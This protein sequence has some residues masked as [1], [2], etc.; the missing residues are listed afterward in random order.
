MT[1]KDDKYA[2]LRQRVIAG[3]IGVIIL[4]TA[5]ASGHWGF[6]AA[7]LLLNYLSL[8]EFY[9]LVRQDGHLP[10]S[11]FGSFAGC[12]L[13]VLTFL[14][15]EQILPRTYFFIM[16]PV[17]AL[18]FFIKLYQSEQKPFIS[19]AFTF[20]GIFY[21]AVPLSLLVVCAYHPGQYS[22][23]I[24]IG[25]L[26]LL[27]GSDTGAYFAGKS[28]GKTPLFP[29]IS[30]KKT[31]EGSIGGAILSLT[32]ATIVSFYFSDLKLWQW[33]GMSGII[34]VTGNLGDLTE[35][36]FKRSLSVKDSG[37]SIPGHGGFL[38]RFD[39]FLLSLPFVTAF[40]EL[41]C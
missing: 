28:L 15:Y 34:V 38:D 18:I 3:V 13:L 20:L 31:W 29:R 5:S 32:V 25:Y 16:F 7:F 37:S 40:L 11:D 9:R 22:W 8:R 26:L 2:N 6:L 35:S 33:L 17:L 30:P 24:V 10:L 14:F 27:W 4:L 36:L 21:I 23:Q 41:F 12:L 19:I 39:G 1:E